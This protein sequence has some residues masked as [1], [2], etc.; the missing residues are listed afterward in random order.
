MIK[1][2]IA[3][4]DIQFTCDYAVYIKGDDSSICYCTSQER[5]ELMVQALGT[6]DLTTRKGV[7]K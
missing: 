3:K 2:E 6:L 4:P 5:A 1:Y 7:D